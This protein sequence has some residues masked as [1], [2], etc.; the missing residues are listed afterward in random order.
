M[1]D[2]FIGGLERSTKIDTMQ[3]VQSASLERKDHVG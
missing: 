3:P 1:N 2:K